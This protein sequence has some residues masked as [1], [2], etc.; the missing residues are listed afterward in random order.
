MKQKTYLDKLME[1]K[2]AKEKID[3]ELK[4]IKDLEDVIINIKKVIKA[5]ADQP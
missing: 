2:E 1:N 4:V 5:N 3:K